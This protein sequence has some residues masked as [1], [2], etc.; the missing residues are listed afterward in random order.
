[1]TAAAGQGAGT[2]AQLAALLDEYAAS[3]AE[4]AAARTPVRRTAAELRRGRII[5]GS[6][7]ATAAKSTARRAPATGKA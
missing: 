4:A 7:A 2:E 5:I 1:M 3:R 6:A